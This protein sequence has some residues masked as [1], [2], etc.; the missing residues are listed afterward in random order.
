MDWTFLELAAGIALAAMTLR[1]VF[2]TVV[3]PGGS[4]ASLH[5]ARRLVFVLLPVWKRL[6]GRRRG[7][8]TMF[9][10]FALVASFAI[11]MGLLAIAFGLMVHAAGTS[12]TPHIT[13]FGDAVFAA[14][15]ALVTIGQSSDT[16]RDGG[17]WVMLAAGFCGLGVMTMAVT[18]LLEVQSSIAHRD[19]GIFKLRTSAGEPPAA[20]ALLEKFAAI[21]AVAELPRILRDGRDWC[22][23]VRQSHT[24][25]PSLIYFRTTGTGSGWPAALGAL[26]DLALIVERW[27]DMPDLRGLAVLLREDGCRM[28]EE[29]GRLIALEPHASP[30]DPKAA[31]G[32]A[33]RL[34][35]AG[36]RQQDGFDPEPFA[37]ERETHCEWIRALAHHLG[38]PEPRLLP[39]D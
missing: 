37:K 36:Y 33:R 12:F 8:S 21:G 39:D 38:R 3:V 22:A 17:R 14:G 24:S 19:S 2:D 11:W 16:V 6:R 28:G 10:P 15:S 29:I 31:S 34:R 23:A 20:V 7:L 5:I 26:L 27:L 25:H 18:Y 30:P 4:H 1:D 35:A 13:S 32:M 9:A